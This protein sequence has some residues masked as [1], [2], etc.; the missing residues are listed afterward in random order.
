MQLYKYLILCLLVI[1]ACA[2]QEEMTESTE[3]KPEYTGEMIDISVDMSMSSVT[4]AYMD[5]LDGTSYPFRWSESGESVMLLE[6]ASLVG[7]DIYTAIQNAASNSRYS[8]SEDGASASFTFYLQELA[9]GDAFEYRCI[10][11]STCLTSAGQEGMKLD[12]PSV[13]TPL[14][15]SPDPTAVLL[16]NTVTGY[17]SQPSSLTFAKGF[18]H[19]LAYVAVTV[20]NLQLTAGETVS[21]VCLSFK[22]KAVT[23]ALAMDW[24]GDCDPTEESR[25]F[26][27]L[28][29]D[30]LNTE[31]NFT[32]RFASI[33]FNLAAGDEFTINVIT[34]TST[35]TRT[36]KVSSEMVFPEGE[37]TSFGLDM[38][39]A[40]RATQTGIRLS[41]G[42]EYSLEEVSDGIFE[43]EIPYEAGNGLTYLYAGKEYGMMAASGSGTVGTHSSGTHLSRTLG[44]LAEAGNPIQLNQSDAE[45]VL[46]RIDLSYGD[47][48]P[49]YYLELPE[50]EEN[51]IWHEDFSLMVWGGDY[52]TYADGLTPTQAA[53]DVDGTEPAT[54]SVT[55]TQAA[56]GNQPF[57][58]DNQVYVK[59]RGLED[60][61]L[62]YCCEKPFSMQVGHAN[63]AGS[64]ITPALTALDGPTDV[65][66]HIDMARFGT[67]GSNVKVEIEIIGSGE[68]EQELCT[69]SR[70]AYVCSYGTYTALTDVLMSD[71]DFVF[72]QDKKVV[73][74]SSNGQGKIFPRA[75]DNCETLKPHTR[76]NMKIRG[77]DKD[78]RIR[79]AGVSAT[80]RFTLFDLK[81][82]KDEGNVV[83]GT[84]IDPSST[85]YGMVRDNTTGKPMAGV[86]VTDGYTYVR[87]D[88]NGVY[89]MAGNELARCIYP[90]IPAE[91]EIPLAEDGQPKI[92]QYVTKGT[93]RYDFDLVQRQTM[94]DDFTML[95]I[96]DVHFYFK[97]EDE[98]TGIDRFNSVHLPDMTEYLS[99]ASASGEISRNVIILNAGDNTCN[100]TNKLPQI[101]EIYN[102]IK[103]DGVTVPMFNA[104][105][106]HDHNPEGLTDYECSEDFVRTFGPTEY[107]INIGKAH[108]V[109]LDNTM[110]VEKEQPQQYGNAMKFVRGVS[111]EKF[112]WLKADLATVKDP[113][114]TLLI[115]CMHAPIFNGSYQ[116]YEL[117]RQIMPTFGESHIITGHLHKEITRDFTSKWTG[118]LGR[119]SQEHNLL[120]LGGSWTHGWA[121]KISVDGTPIGYNV[122]NVSGNML[123]EAFFN[124]VEEP[125]TYQFRIY[126]GSK[127]YGDD[128]TI[129]F[130]GSDGNPVPKTFTFDWTTH[131]A[132]MTAGL[133]APLTD[134]SDK[135]VVRVFAAGTMGQYWK[136]YLVD[137][138]GNRTPMTRIDGNVVDQCT[139]AFFYRHKGWKS[140]DYSTTSAKNVWYVDVPSNYRIY[141]QL[142]FSFGGYKVVAE[143]TSPGGKVYTYESNKM[144][145]DYTGFDY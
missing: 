103:L 104:I 27:S 40:T 108:I 28:K 89:Q 66:L 37:L 99:S 114:N 83:N 142:A 58:E 84:V 72:A 85:L 11:P 93:A 75:Y 14:A 51:V 19:P 111:D 8:V 131:V 54:K 82:V 16:W 121:N 143:Y 3:P 96:T 25:S 31:S 100:Y 110:C 63:G 33:P 79:I 105:G 130:T 126:D 134:M 129:N 12:I 122:F 145:T 24:K 38:I 39:S 124:P 5:K 48:I 61:T 88:A 22:D 44:R 65:N 64:A 127:K 98:T 52:Y 144:Q 76:L 139:L 136:V 112:A 47:G 7:S 59:N 36:V 74:T 60:W 9:N 41:S 135:F 18:S 77:A 123:K 46:V 118:T 13:Q 67:N 71:Y 117:V 94:S 50:T 6:R 2:K 57:D 49:R 101:R 35:L 21:S 20:K 106:N 86:P 120:A 91:Y 73:S 34:S 62:A 4:K 137:K 68:F 45:K 32:V 1:S 10:S 87:T 15:D 23:G 115:L 80:A 30:N 109:F 140:E 70:D 78:T 141:P 133:A 102:Q 97:D 95:A 53:A 43:L 55:Y 128:L 42:A 132:E 56:F 29:T 116:N 119:I 69:A 92:Y 107:S 138:N 26:V 125:D 17:G 81:V 90:S 113:E